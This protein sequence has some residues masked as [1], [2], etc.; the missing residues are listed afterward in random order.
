MRVQK[1]LPLLSY[2]P[3]TLRIITKENAKKQIQKCEN[4]TSLG[5]IR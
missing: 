2:E 3:F 4:T 5:T 1:S